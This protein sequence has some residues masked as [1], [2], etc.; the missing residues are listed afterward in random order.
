M[1]AT[2]L[3]DAPP[4]RF[5]V[6]EHLLA[7]NRGRAARV[8]YIDDRQ[9]LS[10]G[11]LDERVRRFAAGL[12]ALG[13][14]PEQRVLMLLHDSVDFPVA[15]LGAL[16]AGIVPVPVNTLLTGAD[17]VYMLQH[18]RARAVIVSQPLLAT[19]QAAFRESGVDAQIVVSGVEQAP[20]GMHSFASL[21]DG[22]VLAQ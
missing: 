20:E 10:F 1:D 5:N 8:A 9:Q 15:F 22:P 11:A 18:S 2:S 7:R 19:A 6:A 13:V 14:Q 12:L 16:Y 4:E 3:A 17:Y 21:L